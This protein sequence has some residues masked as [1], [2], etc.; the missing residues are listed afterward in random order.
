MLKLAYQLGFQAALEEAGLLKTSF[1]SSAQ[2][3]AEMNRKF[4]VK[5]PAAKPSPGPVTQPSWLK[6]ITKPRQPRQSFGG[7]RSGTTGGG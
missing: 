2:I 1:E 7:T 6:T 5:M 4:P 3:N